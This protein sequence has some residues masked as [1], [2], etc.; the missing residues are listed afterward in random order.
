MPALIF[1]S[2]ERD[3]LICTMCGHVVDSQEDLIG[4]DIYSAC[5]QCDEVA[6]SF[7][8][9]KKQVISMTRILNPFTWFRRKTR[10][11]LRP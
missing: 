7:R 3:L 5:P 4:I 1:Q 6:W 9:G 11:E 2:R 8:V 10:Y